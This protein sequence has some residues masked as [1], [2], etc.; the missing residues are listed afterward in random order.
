MPARSVQL[1]LL[2]LREQREHGVARPQERVQLRARHWIVRNAAGGRMQ[3]VRGEGVN[4]ATP[5][6]AAGERESQDLHPPWIAIF[7]CCDAV[8]PGNLSGAV[9]TSPGPEWLLGQIVIW[10]I[11]CQTVKAVERPSTEEVGLTAVVLL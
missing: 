3:E 5:A 8:L 10:S 7:T 6:L 9:D 2:G 11:P 4:G 1:S